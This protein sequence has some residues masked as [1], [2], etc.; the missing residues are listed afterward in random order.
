MR[1]NARLVQQGQELLRSVG[2][3]PIFG[4]EVLCWAPNRVKG[5]H[6]IDALEPLVERLQETID[7][8]GGYDEVVKVLDKFKDAAAKRG[9]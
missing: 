6:S 8:G 3:D 7:V 2:I 4:K 9:Q 5:Q 1:G